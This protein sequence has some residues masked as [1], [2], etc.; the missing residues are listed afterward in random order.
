MKKV[1]VCISGF[2]RDFE[3][4]HQNLF[5]N[6][7]NNNPNYQFDIFIHT[8]DKIN[9]QSSQ[10]F[11]RG[12]IDGRNAYDNF[13]TYD[14]NRL[15]QIYNPKSICIDRY[16]DD[17]FKKFEKYLIANN[18]AGLG[19][20]NPIAV[21]SQF[22]KVA[23]CAEMAISNEHLTGEKYDIIIRTRFDLNANPINLDDFELTDDMIYLE[24]D[25]SLGDWS[26]D[27]F[28]IMN[29]AVNE[30]YRSF[31]YN[32]ESLIDQTNVCLPE[33]LMAAFF[34]ALN[35]RME[36]TTKIGHLKLY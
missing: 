19:G 5:D 13:N 6:I 31:Y 15:I 22:Y 23:K 25:G 17:N 9:T 35:I 21:F 2:V 18:G 20:N 34:K 4:T 8:W 14:S 29:G 24:N 32:L 28:A 16:G 10:L 7:I 3:K 12:D 1:A 27:K 33:R 11:I 26:S 30:V 36:K